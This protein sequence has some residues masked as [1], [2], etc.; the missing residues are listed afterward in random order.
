MSAI[1]T[2][3]RNAMREQNAYT[4]L[5]RDVIKRPATALVQTWRVAE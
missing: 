2:Q 5:V 3:T 1:P 4:P